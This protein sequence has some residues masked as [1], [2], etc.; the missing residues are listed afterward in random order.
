MR[1]I[2]TPVLFLFTLILNAQN[3]THGPVVGGLTYNSVRIYAR[4]NTPATM[5]V[6][7]S[8]TQS[9]TSYSKYNLTT[10]I[11][12]D[13]SGILA[14]SNLQANTKYFYYLKINGVQQGD[15][16]SFTTFPTDGQDGNYALLFGS[17]ID[18]TTS[19]AVFK[20]MQKHQ[21]NMFFQTGD[22]I[23]SDSN[24]D[25]D[26]GSYYANDY[27]K[28]ANEYHKRYS[29]VNMNQFMLN[30]PIDYV[31]DDH[32]FVNNN[33]TSTECVEFEITWNGVTPTVYTF[34]QYARTNAIKGY[35]E[36]FPGYAMVDTSEGIYHKLTLGNIEVF[37]L[38]D[39]SARSSNVDGLY[40]SGGTYY[41][42]GKSSHTMLGKKQLNWLLNGLKNSTADWKIVVSGV[43]FNKKFQTVLKD[44]L[45]LPGLI[46]VPTGS[47]MMDTWAGY[48]L[49]QDSILGFIKQ[50]CINNTILVSGDSHTSAIDDGANAGFPEMMAANLHKS[51]SQLNW[52]IQY[53]LG[54]ECW[55]MGAQGIG[56]TNFNN[57]FGK[58]E[59][60]QD[61]SLVMKIIDTYGYAIAKC[62]VKNTKPL[63][64]SINIDT[65]SGGKFSAT[66][67]ISGGTSPYTYKWSNGETT[68][69]VSGLSLGQ[70]YVIV[71]DAN[72]CIDSVDLQLTSSPTFISAL[73][74]KELIFDITPNP[75]RRKFQVNVKLA[76][77][78]NI[79]LELLNVEG[80]K[81]KEFSFSNAASASLVADLASYEA[82]IYFIKLTAGDYSIVKRMLKVDY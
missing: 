65:L 44:L 51:N 19:D 42:S 56:N 49:E 18:D 57:T 32:D 59:T 25:P 31:Y 24:N 68:Q 76:K 77:E 81:I 62:T 82:G 55:N 63:N 7:L 38:D 70:Y 40:E 20:E 12:K 73:L 22:W 58:I 45:A 52:M 69:T 17:C 5:E 3:V 26:L 54:I 74:E 72:G 11:A 9:F 6:Q 50:E 67:S 41:F 4:T 78:E 33:S 66:V 15:M 75:T 14:I 23:Y 46:G 8:T 64:A 30:N 1:T 35:V 34:P 28:I 61:D 60:Y 10:S 21:C 13:N 71:S 39:R 16:G 29:S 43:T 79:L 37:V 53:L 47:A 36:Y 80:Q 48:P 27:Y 2:L